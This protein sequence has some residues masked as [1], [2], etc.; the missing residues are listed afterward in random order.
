MK[1]YND[2]RILKYQY[3]IISENMEEYLWKK[4]NEKETKWAVQL[5]LE[6]VNESSESKTE[7]VWDIFFIDSQNQ[8]KIEKILNKYKIEYEITDLTESFLSN[9]NNLPKKFMERL[10]EELQE[11][12]STD[13]ILD[14]II[15]HGVKSLNVFENY[16]LENKTN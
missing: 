10:N 11:N 16:Y 5:T 3:K 8:I 2:Y 14:K 7:A 15:D 12:L 4:M 1:D 9:F 13:E 6:G